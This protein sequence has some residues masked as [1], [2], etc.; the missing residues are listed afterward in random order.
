MQIV[1]GP[2]EVAAPGVVRHFDVRDVRVRGEGDV[3]LIHI[4]AFPHV[5]VR[6]LNRLVVV[7]V[8]QQPI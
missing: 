3:A 4:G 1:Q 5:P 8:L 2:P 6:R 7:P